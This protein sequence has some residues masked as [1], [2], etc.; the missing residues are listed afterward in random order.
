MTTRWAFR[1]L[2]AEARKKANEAVWK[3][4]SAPRKLTMSPKDETLRNKWM[5][6]YID[7]GGKVW[8]ATASTDKRN[9]WIG[10]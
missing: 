4:M 1:P 2:N 3:E 10:L 6:A 7:A 5:D 8:V 9:Q